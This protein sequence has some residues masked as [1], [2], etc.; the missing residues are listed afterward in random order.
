MAGSRLTASQR[1]KIS[2]ALV[3]LKRPQVLI[4]DGIAGGA[5]ASDTALRD[6]IREAAKG[7]TLLYGLDDLEPAEA[8]AYSI[9][10][11]NSRIDAQASPPKD[12]SQL[13]DEAGSLAQGAAS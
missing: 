9:T 2:L 6:G 3:L 8:F 11:V 4:I 10:L 12:T 7:R 1:Q 13:A 5:N